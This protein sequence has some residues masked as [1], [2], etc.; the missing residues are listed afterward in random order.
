MRPSP[1]VGR[2][3]VEVLCKDPNSAVADILSR[4][5]AD[6]RLNVGALNFVNP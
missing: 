1:Y 6:H 5:N 3:I 2:R 4:P